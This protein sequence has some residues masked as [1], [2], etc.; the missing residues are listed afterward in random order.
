MDSK[1]S[2]IPVQ[3]N[4]IWNRNISVL[5]N[6]KRTRKIPVPSGWKRSRVGG[7]GEERKSNKAQSS[8]ARKLP[9]LQILTL[10]ENVF[11]NA[12]I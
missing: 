8:L 5:N 7:K 3:N 2:I 10:L 12:L 11:K 4:W 9:E 6:H 1:Y